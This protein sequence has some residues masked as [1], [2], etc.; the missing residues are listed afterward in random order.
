MK[1]E[2]MDE[3]Q[4]AMQIIAFMAHVEGISED[5]QL[6]PPVEVNA[7]DRSG[8]V[9]DFEYSPEWDGVD[10]YDAPSLPVS[11]RLTDAT[12]RVIKTKIT[13]FTLRPEW[14]QKLQ[15]LLQ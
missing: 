4:I 11:L 9:F 12:G 13:D 10:L 5:E 14:V 3:K 2:G 8:T 7:T 1:G 15:K 6:V